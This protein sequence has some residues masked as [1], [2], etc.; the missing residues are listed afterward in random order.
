MTHQS[1]TTLGVQPNWNIPALADAREVICR[2]NAAGFEA[3]IVGGAVRD[4][5]LGLPL[6]D[7]DVATIATPEE[8]ERIFPQTVGVGR[9][10]GVMIVVTREGRHVEVATY[11]TDGP[12]GDGRHPEGVAYAR[13]LAEDVA[14]RD[15]TV[16]ALA[17]DVERME[18]IDQVDGLGDLKRRLIRA[19]GDPARRFVEDRLRVLRAAR[20]AAR[21]DFSIE[22][23]TWQA[24]QSADLSPLSRERLL[25]EWRKAMN[26]P[27]RW[28]YLEL[29]K[30]FLP[31]LVPPLQNVKLPTLAIVPDWIAATA[32]LMVQDL[33]NGGTF[34]AWE[35]WTKTWP[36]ATAERNALL[37]LAKKVL[38]V[39]GFLSARSAY[40]LRQAAESDANS[41]I[42]LWRALKSETDLIAAETLE[43]LVS[44]HRS[45]P[46]PFVT[47][48]DCLA[49]GLRGPQIG[50]L[51][52]EALDLQWEG[53]LKTREDALKWLAHRISSHGS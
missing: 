29:V 21:L 53:T 49:L 23:A 34:Q 8:I 32:L 9:S 2:L 52:S 48:A 31:T 35:E 14:R 42:A 4:L 24:M 11:R 17:I 22:T 47:G 51:L 27:S 44:Q 25:D 50:T 1:L 26:H 38:N 36:F 33:R 18:I 16:N 20:F 46:T 30:Q 7:A 19:V 28:C 12:A 15:F 40:R 3:C 45:S 43:T 6:H 41:V 37:V 10:F 13:T 5:L 39:E